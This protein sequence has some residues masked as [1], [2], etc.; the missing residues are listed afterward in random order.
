MESSNMKNMIVLKNLH[1]NLIEEAIV[2]LKNNVNIK[3]PQTEGAK[4]E[5]ENSDKK[6]EYM[7][8]EAQMHIAQYVSNMEKDAKVNK[9]NK[10]WEKKYMRLKRITS[11]FAIIAILGM[12]VNMLK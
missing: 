5:K 1:S 12:V 11:F 7:I 4:K 10:D 6:S 3:I 9:L 8:K 2:V